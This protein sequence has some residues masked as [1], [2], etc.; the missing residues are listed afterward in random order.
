MTILTKPVRRLASVD[1]GRV[2]IAVTINPGGTLTFREKG[3][4]REYTI[5]IMSAYRLAVEQ[6]RPIKQGRIK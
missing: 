3:S 1:G 2:D 4:R 6:N 5:T